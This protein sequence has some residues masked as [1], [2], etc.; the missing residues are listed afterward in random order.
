MQGTKLRIKTCQEE[1]PLCPGST[2][3]LLPRRVIDVG[4][5]D[6]TTL[7]LYET[8]QN[9][10]AH[11]ATLSY[12]WGTK[13]Q[14][15]TTLD[16]MA[17]LL[18]D[19][20]KYNLSQTHLDAIQVSR[21]LGIRYLWIDALCITQD[22]PADMMI[23]MPNMGNI[24]KNSTITIVASEAQSAHSGFLGTLKYPPTVPLPFLLPDGSEETVLLSYHKAKWPAK[25]HLD[26]RGWTL[27]ESLLSPRLIIFGY[28]E[29]RWQC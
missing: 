19:M 6:G 23:H 29:V 8:K 12:C 25:G 28:S 1:H 24:Y 13:P 2:F 10:R 22:N 5:K 17:G 9:E 16:L 3:P 27:Q 18:Y 4:G 11:Y 15:T 14:F 26:T 20:S 7:K 21:G